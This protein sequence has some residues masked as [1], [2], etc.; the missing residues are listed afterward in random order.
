MAEQGFSKGMS[1]MMLG[2]IAGATTL[3]VGLTGFMVTGLRKSNAT[4]VAE[5]YQLRYSR[6]VRI[7][8][9]VV[10]ATAGVLNYGI[11]LRIEADFVRFITG[12]GT[13][14][15]NVPGFGLVDSVKIWMTILVV[16][17]LT[18]T[19]VGGMVSVVL[20]DYIQ[21]IVLSAGMAATTYWVL[22]K[23]DIGGLPGIIEA[24]RVERPEYG[25]NPFVRQGV[26]GMGVVW[27]MW[28]TMHWTATNTW[29]TQAFRTAATDSPRTARIMWGLTGI[30][31]FGRAIIPMLW[32]VAA[33]AW[34]SRQGGT[35]GVNSIEAMPRYLA[36]LPAGLVGFL[37]AGMLAALM[38]TH[39]G[40]LLAWS[41]V[42]TE[43]LIAPA[44]EA[45]GAPNGPKWRIRITR[46]L[47]LALGGFLLGWGL[48]FKPPGPIWEYL[49]LT[50]TMYLAGSATLVAMGLYWSRAST[51]GAYLGIILGALPGLTYLF[52][53][54]A[55]L[56][57][58]PGM[59]DA[60]YVPIGAIAQASR[61]LTEPH[62][63]IISY[64]LALTGMILGSLLF[65]RRD[66]AGEARL[67]EVTP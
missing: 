39:S 50:G 35:A 61:Q 32:G 64:P 1:S 52:L 66:A 2:I 49:G 3:I 24:V 9:G 18:Y 60:T 25:L 37:L 62:V 22:F 12:V 47:I 48:W 14:A 59:R 55:A 21:F 16:L 46:L 67:Q 28:Q 65:P 4:T 57:L 63:G 53:R 17:V 33:L 13:E 38:S 42:I 56:V 27:I 23:S 19:L 44:A 26:L 8:G 15:L 30:N 54:I 41:G 10:I 11:F 5:Y 58:E 36:N 6:G 40:Y 34:F 7:L 43:D 20:T 45:L 51:G 29:Q 31:Y